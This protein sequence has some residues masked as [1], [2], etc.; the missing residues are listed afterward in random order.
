MSDQSPKKVIGASDFLPNERRKAFDDA[1]RGLNFTKDFTSA[2]EAIM[3]DPM[4]TNGERFLA[5]LKRRAWG[6][7]SLYAIRADGQP[8]YQRDAAADLKIDKR[9]LTN[10]VGYLKNR[11]YLRTEGKLLFPVIAP[12]LSIPEKVARSYDFS[13]F[14]EQWKVAHSNDFQALEVARSTVER[15][16]KVILSDYKKARASTTNAAPSLLREQ[17]LSERPDSVSSVSPDQAQPIAG[18]TTTTDDTPHINRSLKPTPGTTAEG[19]E[20]RAAFRDAIPDS[21]LSLAQAEKLIAQ[22]R[23][24]APEA[25]VAD[26][27]RGI[28]AK[29]RQARRAESPV[30]F[31]LSSLPNWFEGNWRARSADGERA[32]QLSDEE[33]ARIIAETD[34]K[35]KEFG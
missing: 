32:Q 31:M 34:R 11:G 3:G 6:N 8:A 25:S 35:L 24:I 21:D 5:W 20:I 29:T 33:R 13:K 12:E 22:C 28:D 15:I 14:I 30:G 4:A 10:V 7:Y 17:E 18:K 9:N 27:R 23:Q 2:Q 16:R 26:I 1:T 19:E